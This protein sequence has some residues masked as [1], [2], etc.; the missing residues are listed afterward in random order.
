LHD[1][2]TRGWRN[3]RTAKGNAT[4]SWRDKMTRGFDSE[5]IQSWRNDDQPTITIFLHLNFSG[6]IGKQ[7]ANPNEVILQPMLWRHSIDASI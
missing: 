5:P 4:T 2:L 7:N 1:E 3:E 6:R